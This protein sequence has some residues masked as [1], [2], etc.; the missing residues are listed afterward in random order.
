MQGHTEGSVARYLELSGKHSSSLHLIATPCLDDHMLDAEDD[1]T[2]G[3]SKEES[4]T[5]WLKALYVARYNHLDLSWSVDS[6][7]EKLQRGQ[8]IAIGVCID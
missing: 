5:I 8:L 4:A 6:L 2:K 7:D 3:V 1:H